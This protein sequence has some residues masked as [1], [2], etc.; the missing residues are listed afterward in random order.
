MLCQE[1]LLRPFFMEENIG[2]DK[3]V[4]FSNAASDLPDNIPILLDFFHFAIGEGQCCN[5]ESR[6]K[7]RDKDGEFQF[8]ADF[9]I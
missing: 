6:H 3:M 2:K 7:R 9:H 4:E 1:L 8:G 5:N